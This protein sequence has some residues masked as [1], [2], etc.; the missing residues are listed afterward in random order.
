MN[1]KEIIDQYSFSEKSQYDDNFLKIIQDDLKDIEQDLNYSS[2]S[3]DLYGKLIEI[4][5]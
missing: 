2:T 3:N 1:I 5:N 4:K